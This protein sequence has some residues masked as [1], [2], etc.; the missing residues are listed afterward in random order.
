MSR[1]P[2][3]QPTCSSGTCRARP[4]QAQAAGSA[5]PHPPGLGGPPW[6]AV[7]LDSEVSSSDPWSAVS[8]NK[9]DGSSRLAAL[10]RQPCRPRGGSYGTDRQTDRQGNPL[11]VD[12]AAQG[13]PPEGQD[14]KSG[15]GRPS[16]PHPRVLSR[17][18]S[19]V[20]KGKGAPRAPPKLTGWPWTSLFPGRLLNFHV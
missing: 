12:S 11:T 10:P 16:P 7:L 1:R 3:A 17:R 8:T 14:P 20:R 5:Q 6:P 19:P 15:P 18:S 13:V 4:D 9:A 2:Q